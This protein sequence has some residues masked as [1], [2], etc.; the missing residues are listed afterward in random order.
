MKNFVKK[1][2]SYKIKYL[3]YRS[4]VSKD[5]SSQITIHSSAQISNCHISTRNGGKITIK[6]NVKISDFNIMV[7]NGVLEI[8]ENNILCKGNNGVKPQIIIENGTFRLGKNNMFKAKLW[9]RFSGSII[10]GSYNAINEG[11]EIR[12]DER[13]EIGDFNMISYDCMIFDTNTHVIYPVNK[14]RE[15]TIKE[16]PVM[17]REI[18]RPDCAPVLIGDDCWMGKRSVILKGTEF[19]NR[20]ILGTSSVVSK[21]TINS[22]GVIVGNPG[23]LIGVK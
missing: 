23:K 12:C 5:K 13:I 19:Q 16:F 15:L 2:F 1:V 9:V 3:L 18:E 21:K 17:G 22:G 20:V 6:E 11:T 10:I 4:F 8:S 7:H 14:R